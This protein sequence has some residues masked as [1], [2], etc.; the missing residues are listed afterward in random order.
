M[1]LL[2]L[3]SFRLFKT[4]PNIVVTR[5]KFQ[6]SIYLST[7]F[8]SF[9]RIFLLC[10]EPAYKDH[11]GKNFSKKILSKKEKLQ[12]EVNEWISSKHNMG[13]AFTRSNH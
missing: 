13:M 2:D 4:I 6:M 10:M 5:N 9:Y 7:F 8:L 11:L 3:C 1:I 12:V